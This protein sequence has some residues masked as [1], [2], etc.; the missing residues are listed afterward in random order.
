MIHGSAHSMAHWNITYLVSLSFFS[1][2][3]HIIIY[4]FLF[5]RRNSI[6]L[7]RKG[8]FFPVDM[9]SIHIQSSIE[10]VSLL[11]RDRDKMKTQI[12][13]WKTLTF[14]NDEK[15]KIT[16]NDNAN[17]TMNAFPNRGIERIDFFLISFSQ[18]QNR[19]ETVTRYSIDGWY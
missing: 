14:R 1:L 6:C 10:C 11:N 19:D 3:W 4:L 13:K 5:R 17:K 16:L 2:I 8:I 9:K 12:N 7:V 15:S 18:W